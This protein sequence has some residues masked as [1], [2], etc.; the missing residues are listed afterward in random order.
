MSRISEVFKHRGVDGTRA[1]I[2]FVTAGDPTLAHTLPALN[3][4]VQGGVDILELGVPFSDPEAEGPAIQRSSE[5]ALA[6][7]VTLDQVLDVVRQFRETDQ[8]TAVVL[9]GYLNSILAMDQ[10]AEKA[11]GAGVDGLIMVNLPPEEATEIQAQLLAHDIDLIYLLA[12]TTT[13]ERA[14]FILSKTSGFA[15]CVSLKGITGADNLRTAE[16]A[17]KLQALRAM[18][19]VP[20]CVGFGI[21]DATTAAQ[22]GEYADGVVVGSA[23]VNLMTQEQSPVDVAASLKQAAAKLRDGLD[24]LG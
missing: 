17:D 15:Y 2:S 3:A 23:L 24:S 9:M 5:R 22:V 12:P 19:N 8:T 21:K 6:N 7:G 4:L 20:L 16:V 13:A 10:F 18:S 14:K 11:S 1:L